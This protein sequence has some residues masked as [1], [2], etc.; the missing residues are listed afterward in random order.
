MTS[1]R[2]RAPSVV[3]VSVTCLLVVVLFVRVRAAK[4]RQVR[5][6]VR[7]R[8]AHVGERV[9]AGRRSGRRVRRHE[10]PPGPPRSRPR[11]APHRLLPTR[12]RRSRRAQG[13]TWPADQPPGP[14]PRTGTT[15]AAARRRAPTLRA[16]L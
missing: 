2:R 7:P 5:R 9:G 11:Q 10:D 16:A 4:P 13:Y 12:A 15:S 6:A 1:R 3:V 8:P 14:T